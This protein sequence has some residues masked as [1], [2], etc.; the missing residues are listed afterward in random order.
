[1]HPMHLEGP[2]GVWFPK[3]P[4]CSGH[5]GV[6]TPLPYLG[7]GDVAARTPPVLQGGPV[8]NHVPAGLPDEDRGH[9]REICK[10]TWLLKRLQPV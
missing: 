3:P 5:F 1:M 8:V 7:P 9:L 4:G 6:R 2:V 10:D